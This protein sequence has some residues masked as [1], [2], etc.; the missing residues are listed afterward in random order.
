MCVLR[1]GAH[2][3]RPWNVVLAAGSRKKRC[4]TDSSARVPSLTRCSSGV[5]R[6][7]D[8]FV[9]SPAR[10]CA[11]IEKV[12]TRIA[13]RY[14]GDGGRLDGDSGGPA[15]HV[16]PVD[17]TGHDG[18]SVPGEDERLHRSVG[19]GCCV[20]RD[21]AALR[22]GPSSRE[23]VHDGCPTSDS[24][25]SVFSDG[26]SSAIDGLFDLSRRVLR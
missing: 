19:S 7:K 20:G 15:L 22:T 25:G 8:E 16:L 13:Q 1:N 17:E 3:L 4:G 9:L 10:G 24:S 6:R 18:H 5:E 2:F 14:H 26:N 21:F 11:R 23:R 12:R